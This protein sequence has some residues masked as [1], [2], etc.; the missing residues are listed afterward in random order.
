MI[1]PKRLNEFSKPQLKIIFNKENNKFNG[2]FLKMIAKYE[3]YLKT[4]DVAKEIGVSKST[5]K[6]WDNEG[7]LSADKHTDSNIRLYKQ[8]TIQNFIRDNLEV[9]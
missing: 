7:Y 6:N 4:G 1:N 5:I 9:V 8:E 2:G 3:G